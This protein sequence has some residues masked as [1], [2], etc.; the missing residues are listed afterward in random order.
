MKKEDNIMLWSARGALAIVYIWFGALKLFDA[1]PANPLVADLLERTLPFLT[2]SQFIVGLG[3][4]E[5]LIGLLFLVPRANYAALG[6]LVIHLI[7]TT[8]PLVLLPAV[9]WSGAFVPTLEGQY[10]IKNVLIVVAGIVVAVEHHR[11]SVRA[12]RLRHHHFEQARH[13]HYA[14]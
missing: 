2:F 14:R 4:F 1:S 9:A 5:V 8:G 7:M 6:A 3:V 11:E 10:I 13:N 12:H